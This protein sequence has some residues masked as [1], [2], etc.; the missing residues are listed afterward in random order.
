LTDGFRRAG[1]DS[2]APVPAAAFN[3]TTS[4]S[5]NSRHSPFAIRSSTIGPKRTRF[6]RTTG[7][8][9]A[10]HILRTWRGRPSWSVI[11]IID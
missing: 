10:S 9:T 6:N 2:D 8:R 1:P 11:A 7:W 3:R 4:R 5:V